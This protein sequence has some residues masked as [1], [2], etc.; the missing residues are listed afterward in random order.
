M[1]D[2]PVIPPGALRYPLAVAGGG[3]ACGY[4]SQLPRG[5]TDWGCAPLRDAGVS[6]ATLSTSP[7]PISRIRAYPGSSA[8]ARSTARAATMLAE[9][10]ARYAI[11]PVLRREAHGGPRA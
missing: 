9:I 2:G 6:V 8:L 3:R 5:S 4:P 7:R 10:V 11:E 1:R